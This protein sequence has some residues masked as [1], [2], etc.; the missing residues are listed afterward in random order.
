MSDLDKPIIALNEIIN[1]EILK[2]TLVS[3]K[4]I[5]DQTQSLTDI[6]NY[7]SAIIQDVVKKIENQPHIVKISELIKL[8]SYDPKNYYIY[9][10]LGLSYKALDLQD[11]ARTFFN[12]S[13]SF[14]PNCVN[15][16]FELGQ[17]YHHIDNKLAIRYLKKVISF[18]TISLPLPI[19]ILSAALFELSLIYMDSFMYNDADIVMKQLINTVGVDEETKLKASLNYNTLRSLMGYG[20]GS[21]SVDLDIYDK[22]GLNKEALHTKLL[23]LNNTLE[24]GSYILKEHLKVNDYFPKSPTKYYEIGQKVPKLLNNRIKIGYVSADLRSHAIVKFMFN[25]LKYHDNSL[26]EIYIFYNFKLYDPITFYIK[27]EFIEKRSNK[28]LDI[29]TMSDNDV[30]AYIFNEKIDILIDLSGHTFGNRL[31]IFKMKPAP[32]QIT[33]LG[34]PN[35]TGLLEMDYRITDSIVDQSHKFYSEKLLRMSGCFLNYVPMIYNSQCQFFDIKPD[36]LNET[37]VSLTNN[38]EITFGLINRP[39]KNNEIF[40]S[41]CSKILEK[42]PNSKILIKIKTRD[43]FIKNYYTDVLKISEDRLI[44]VE[45]MDNNDTYFRLYNKIDILLDTYPYSGTTTTCDALYM[46]VP[47]LTILENNDFRNSGP[48]NVSAS[49]LSNMSS[50]ENNE[51]LIANNPED[52]INKASLLAGNRE[53]INYFKKNIRTSFLE[54]MEP[55]KF[56]KNYEKVLKDLIN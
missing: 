7:K 47:V 18:N 17:M 14:E 48:T 53:L 33:Y 39:A 28:W 34:Y 35:T 38:S 15:N 42:V 41:M 21:A 27:S 54:S 3:L 24:K 37:K 56:M 44:L 26:F 4:D 43:Q 19:N 52:Y 22:L 10:L 29:N 23:L 50:L 16:Y 6:S 12:M 1:N 36:L 9:Y 20:F 8:L 45:Y 30:A 5:S 25:I 40:M 46:S 51:S 2:D 11:H 32:I 49:I 55:L 31:G 13:I